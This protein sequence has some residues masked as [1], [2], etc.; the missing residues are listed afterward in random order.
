MPRVFFSFALLFGLLPGPTVAATS[1]DAVYFGQTHVQKTTDPYFVLSGNRETLIKAHVVDPATPAAPAV[2]AILSLNGDTLN[3]SLTGPPTLPATVPDGPGV[4]QHTNSNTFTAIIPAAWVKPGLGV[5][6]QAG[7]ASASFPT[8][9]IRAPTQVNLTMTDIHFFSLTPGDYPAGWESELEAK[10]P[11][12]R[13]VVNRANDVVFPEL[14]IPPRSGAPAAR[15]TSKQDYLDQTGIAWDG[16]NSAATAWNVALRRAAGRTV[17]Y[18]LYYLNKYNVANE[19]VA[20]GFSGVG[21][22]NAGS[23][24]ILHHELGHALSLPHW[25]DSSAYPYKGA[26]DGIQPPAVY[27][28]THAGPVW[29][30]HLPTRA[31]IPCTIQS[32]NASGAPAGTYKQDPMQGGG[33]GHQESGYIFNHFSDYSV[34]QMRD[35]LQNTVVVWNEALGSYAKWNNTTKGYTTLLTN[36][37]IQYPLL[38]DQSVISIIASVSGASPD[39][40]MV[41]PPIGPYTTGLIRLFDP[42]NAADRAAAVS[43]G[44]SPAGGSDV[45]LRVTQGGNTRTYMLAASYDT[46]ADPL[47]AGSLFTEG[48]NLPAADGSIT[49]VELLLT[50]DAQVNGLPANPQ[51]LYTWTPATPPSPNPAT[52]AVAPSATGPFSIT[53]TATI[54]IGDSDFNG[55][56]EYLFTETSGNLGGTSS[57]WQSSPVYTDTNLQPSTTY[58]Y[59]VSVRSGVSKATGTPSA[60]A[61]ATTGPSVATKTIHTVGGPNS[62]TTGTWTSGIP[63]G[64][65]EAEIASGVAAQNAVTIPAWSGPLILQ[66]GSSLRIHTG[67]ESILNGMTSLTLNN[68][69]IFDT[70]GVINGAG[71]QNFPPIHLRGGGAFDTLF[72]ADPRLDARVFAGVISGDGGFSTFGRGLTTYKFNAANTFTGG[73]VVNNYERHVIELNAPMAAG[74]GNVTVLKDGDSDYSAVLRLGANNVFHPHAILSLNGRG[75]NGVS[76]FDYGGKFTQLDMKSFHACVARLIINGVEQAPGTYTGT[77]TGSDWI[78]GTGTLTVTGVYG[79]FAWIADHPSVGTRVGPTDNPDGDS[80]DNLLE[81]AFGTHPATTNIASIAYVADGALTTPGAPRA[82]DLDAGPGTDFHAVFA[83]RKNH[84]AAG[85]IYTVQFTAD[86]TTWTNSTETPSPLTGLSNPAEVEAVAVRYPAQVPLTG[87]GTEKPTFFRILVS[88]P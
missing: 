4:V 37:G 31:Y 34:R 16:E 5:T 3:L 63:T 25:G 32:N 68:A 42:T 57:G 39:V 48:I 59:T 62:W 29:A 33:T 15:V 85:L 51:V 21:T 8:L 67:G 12:S 36:N 43:T 7:A 64:T 38:R 86:L 60:A 84:L 18:S 45:C 40:C 14:V 80:L 22:G 30:F 82:L 78:D 1:I 41:Y 65:I 76:S 61:G 69:K 72:H 83:R 58:S 20:G 26:M 47:S 81:Y 28:E 79:Y 24:G 27:N 73:L 23:V 11:V 53:M 56:V 70:F 35:Y 49:R 6:I 55:Q 17:G 71:S 75:W 46:G 77:S 88:M 10:W 52:F 19:G 44:F 2:V 74:R 13:L 66:P 87:G 50:P 9:D 54:A